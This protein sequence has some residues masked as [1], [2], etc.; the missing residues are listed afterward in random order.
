MTDPFLLR[1]RLALGGVAEPGEER[2][3]VGGV[4]LFDAR[5]RDDARASSRLATFAQAISRTSA[6]APSN[7]SN[8]GRA[9]AVRSLRNPTTFTAQPSISAGCASAIRPASA[10]MAAS[11]LATV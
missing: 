9:P 10:S 6:T 11:A 1:L 5:S 8:T 2:P 3:A 7:A 4:R